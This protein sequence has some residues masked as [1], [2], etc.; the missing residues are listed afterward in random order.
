MCKKSRYDIVSYLC[1]ARSLIDQASEMWCW[2][3]FWIWA[4]FTRYIISILVEI[5]RILQS[6]SENNNALAQARG[7]FKQLIL[8]RSHN[9]AYFVSLP[10]NIPNYVFTRWHDTQRVK[11]GSRVSVK[12]VDYLVDWYSVAALVDRAYAAATVYSAGAAIQ[13]L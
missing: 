13:D 6:T 5:S 11:P 9:V 3:A 2:R 4:D 8:V 7:L 1:N 12:A 10:R